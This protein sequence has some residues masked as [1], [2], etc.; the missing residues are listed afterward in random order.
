MFQIFNVN[1]DAPQEAILIVA[2]FQ[3]PLMIAAF[4]RSIANPPVRDD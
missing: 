4:L 3:N 1:P 2:S